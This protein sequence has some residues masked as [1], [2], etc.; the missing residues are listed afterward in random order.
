MN[1]VVGPS[2]NIRNRIGVRGVVV[3]RLEQ[4]LRFL[5]VYLWHF[6]CC[7]TSV[8]ASFLFHASSSATLLRLINIRIIEARE[9]V[10]LFRLKVICD[11]GCSSRRSPRTLL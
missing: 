2:G 7:A 9:L 4:F 6:C 11:R 10:I 5:N 8:F 3:W 1:L